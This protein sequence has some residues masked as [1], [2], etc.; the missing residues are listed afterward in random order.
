[1][2]RSTSCASTGSWS[3]S[4]RQEARDS[5]AESRVAGTRRSRAGRLRAFLRARGRQDRHPLSPTRLRSGKG[6][7]CS[8]LNRSADWISWRTPCGHTSRRARTPTSLS[9]RPIDGSHAQ[10]VCQYGRRLAEA[11]GANVEWVLAGCFRHDLDRF[12]AYRLLQ[13]GAPH[14]S[15]LPT[16]CD[17]AGRR[18]ERLNSYA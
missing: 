13:R 4:D 8:M 1:V 6:S 7:R 18:L 2:A 3:S 9:R 12:T 15:S 5:P 10:R 17:E 11:E 14:P 16:L